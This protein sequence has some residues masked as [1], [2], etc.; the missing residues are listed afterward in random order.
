MKSTTMMMRLLAAVAVVGALLGG[1]FAPGAAFAQDA[2]PAS[3]PSQEHCGDH[4]LRELLFRETAIQT[5]QTPRQVERQLR[6]GRSLSEIAAAHG[7]SERAVIG[8]A[9]DRLSRRL[10][11]AVANGRITAE[12]KVRIMAKA[13]ERAPVIMNFKRQPA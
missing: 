11:A 5:D 7:S 9:M 2:K 10:D 3:C 1:L 13:R 8:A 6:E 4:A 12:Q